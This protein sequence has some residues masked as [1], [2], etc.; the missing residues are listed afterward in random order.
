VALL[1]RMSGT[2]MIMAAARKRNAAAGDTAVRLYGP[3][4]PAGKGPLTRARGAYQPARTARK[5]G[6]SQGHYR[7]PPVQTGH[8]VYR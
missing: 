1:A 5:S 4:N 2:E 3:R 7:I 8:N 6:K